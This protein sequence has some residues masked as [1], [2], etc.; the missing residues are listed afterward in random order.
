MMNLTLERRY[1][2]NLATKVR[3]AYFKDGLR[4]VILRARWKLFQGTF[5][6]LYTQYDFDFTPL[7][8]SVVCNFSITAGKP[9]DVEL[10]RGLSREQRSGLTKE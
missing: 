6:S 9:A 3:N 4:G 8:E 7:P 2:M 1:M 10:G 5:S